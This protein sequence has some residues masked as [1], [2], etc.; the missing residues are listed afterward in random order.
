[1][2]NG[3]RIVK[4]KTA[5]LCRLRGFLKRGQALC[6]H[7][8][9]LLTDTMMEDWRDQRLEEVKPGTEARLGGRSVSR[10]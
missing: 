10:R 9:S 6:A 7:A 3:T 8:M 1:M 4:G 5:E 2:E